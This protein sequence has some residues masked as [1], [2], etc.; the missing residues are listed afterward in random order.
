MKFEFMKKKVIII[1]TTMYSAELRVIMNKEGIDV[2]AF[3]VDG[4]YKS[5]SVFNGLPVYEIEKLEDLVDM[6]CVEIILG[7]GYSRMNDVR[8]EKY[9]ECKNKGYQ[10]GTFCSSYATVLTDK[11]GQG[12]VIMPRSYVGPYSEVGFC[13][14]IRAG[15]VLSHH[16]KLGDFNWIADGCVF[17]GGVKM[18]NNSFIGLGSTIRNEILINDYTFVGAHSY[19][20]G[21]TIENTPYLGSPAKAIPHQT[22]HDII[23]KV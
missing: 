19:L 6:S 7:L 22:S 3:S 18:G 17:G 11:I 23:S 20:G 14:V 1:G 4:K 5:E 13:N 9:F 2:L 10:I 15:S 16:D 21:N 8:K 12:S